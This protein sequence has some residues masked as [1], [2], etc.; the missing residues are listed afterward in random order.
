MSSLFESRDSFSNFPPLAKAIKLSSSLICDR[1]AKEIQIHLN[2]LIHS[3]SQQI[4][5]ITSIPKRTT[6][7]SS[8]P[9]RASRT[10]SL[11]S[12]TP[13]SPMSPTTPRAPTALHP[14]SSVTFSSIHNSIDDN[15][16]HKQITKPYH[17]ATLYVLIKIC[18]TDLEY[19]EKGTGHPEG[20]ISDM[21]YSHPKLLYMCR[22]TKL[23]DQRKLIENILTDLGKMKENVYK[24]L[25]TKN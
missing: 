16:S 7:L 20:R 18:L 10:P 15:L 19:W 17:W 24:L 25:R 9:F 8:D 11:T 14:K 21:F 6:S 13:R 5:I 12:T 2:D 4:S 23:K 1:P 3:I 22:E